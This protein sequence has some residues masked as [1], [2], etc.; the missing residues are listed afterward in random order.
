MRAFPPGEVKI[1]GLSCL[2]ESIDWCGEA[3]FLQGTDTK[4]E[5]GR[6]GGFEVLQ[7]GAVLDQLYTGAV[8]A[9]GPVYFPETGTL[10][11]SDIPNNRL[12]QWGPDGTTRTIDDDSKYTNGNTR[13]ANGCRISCQHLSNSVVRLERDGSK[14]VLADTYGGKRLNSPNDVV[15]ASDG[16]VWFTD[17]SYGILSDHEGRARPSEQD[18]CFVF[19]IDPAT[20]D[21]KSVCETLIMPN[22]LAFSPDESVLYVADSSRSHFPGA[23]HHVFAF[24]V[25]PDGTLRNERRFYEIEHGVPDGMR[26]DEFGNLWCSSG[27]GIEVID[28]AG[29]LISHIPVP[30]TVANLTFGGADGNRIFITA[31]TSLYAIDAAV[32]GVETLRSASDRTAK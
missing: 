14:T 9:E 3:Q 2:N 20:G 32:R 8:W 29:T 7:P 16:G 12:L 25:L 23:N 13:D 24:D 22:G 18:G 10:V 19:R 26:V 27:R 30:E 5:P 15:V 31:T 6:S 21:C 17:P 11:F 1:A 4:A 28:P